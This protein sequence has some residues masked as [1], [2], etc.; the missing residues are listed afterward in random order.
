MT[1][2][3]AHLQI[4]GSSLLV[5]S[6]AH[7]FFGRHLDWKNDLAKLTPVNRQIFYVHTFFICLMLVMM[8]SL[9][10]FFPRYLLDRTPLARLILIGLTIFW[11]TR[12]AFQWFVYDSSLWRGHRTNTIVHIVFSLLWSYYTLVF[13]AAYFV[14]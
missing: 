12:L 1:H 14:S 11:G 3:I 13:S 9:C 6:A 5:L 10:L 4:V 8:G 2:F 7:V